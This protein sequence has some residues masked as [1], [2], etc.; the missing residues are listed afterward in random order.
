MRASRFKCVIDSIYKS[1]ERHIYVDFE[2]TVYLPEAVGG[3]PVHVK[4]LETDL[5]LFSHGVGDLARTV[6]FGKISLQS[7]NEPIIV[8]VRASSALRHEPEANLL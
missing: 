1:P 5:P 3:V 2:I 8:E 6:N 7:A 4:N